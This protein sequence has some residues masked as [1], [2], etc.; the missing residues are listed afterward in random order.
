ML[1]REEIVLIALGANLGQRIET[2]NLAVSMLQSLG[3]NNVEASA[4]YSTEPVGFVDQPD[5]VNMA[6]RATTMLQPLE[7][8]AACSSVELALG[9]KPREHWH[10]REIDIDVIFYGSTVMND[11]ALTIP[12]PRMQDRRFVLVPAAEIASELTHPV[13]HLSVGALL[14]SCLD[15]SRVEVLLQ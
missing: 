11:P 3:L 13:L 6:I 10:E 5:F 2:L 8:S 7:L 15:T 4:K 14:S 12:H 1:D 9:R